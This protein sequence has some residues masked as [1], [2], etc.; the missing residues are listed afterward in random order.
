MVTMST[1]KNP[2]IKSA[3][4]STVLTSLRSVLDS[5][6][7][8][9]YG[10]DFH[11]AIPVDVEGQKFVKLDLT[12]ANWYDTKTTKAFDPQTLR[13]EYLAEQ[14]IKAKAAEEKR[15]AREAKKASK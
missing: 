2:E 11:L 4:K 3:M 6:G 14:E 12:A 9:P 7:A 8:I 5:L 13:E 1:M 10:D 15:L